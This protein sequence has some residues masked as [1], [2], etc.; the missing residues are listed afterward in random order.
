MPG[1]GIHLATLTIT[2]TMD[3]DGTEQLTIEHA[4]NH[5]TAQL[6]GMLEMGKDMVLR[7]D[8]WCDCHDHECDHD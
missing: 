4:D 2:L 6:V 3:S 5:S 1:T 8:D 7:A